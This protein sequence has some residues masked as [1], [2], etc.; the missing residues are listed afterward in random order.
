MQQVVSRAEWAAVAATALLLIL[1]FPNFEFYPLAWIALVPLIVVIARRPSPLRAFMYGWTAGTLFFYCS[2]YWL[3]YSMIHYGGLPTV[4]AYLLLVPAAL[5][6]GIFPGLFALLL[7]LAVQRWG[8]M[9]LVLAP[10][11]W[12]ALEWTRL[13]VTGQL[14]N[15]IGYSQAYEPLLI[16]AAT[17]GGVYAVSFLIL[18][19]NSAV[20]LL[21]L[22]RTKW[23]ILAAALMVLFVWFAIPLSAYVQAGSRYYS[24]D[25][26]SVAVV[27]LQPNVPMKLV[28]T[29]EEMKEL[30][31][32]HF[33]MSTTAL[34]SLSRDRGPIVVIWPE[35][36]MNFTYARD[37]AFQ[38][39]LTKFTKENRT[40]LIFNS[41]EPAPPDG[42]YNSALLINEWGGLIS[43]YDKIRLMPFGEYV[44]LPRWL[45]GASLITGL[46]GE[47]TPGTNYRLMPLGEHKAG[48]FI[49]IES[50]Y[51]WIARRM[52]SEGADFLINISNDG[53]L[54]PTAVMRQHLANAV[55]RAVENR[56][57][58]MRATN[59]GLSAYI[60]DH[61]KI[62]GQ[63]RAFQ[64]D[65]RVWT[66]SRA[67][68]VTDTI[69]TKHGDFFVH[70]CAVI[71]LAVLIA[72]LFKPAA[73]VM[74]SRS[75]GY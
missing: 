38:E 48:V 74:R 21:V 68:G 40:S 23:T 64:A 24:S 50:A 66:F 26:S 37:T 56:R 29:P 19:I 34:K 10:V 33:T 54:G 28:K 3:T 39:L 35:S 58:V 73:L 14:W 44:P 1:S 15:A 45:P 65:V 13:S 72:L 12:T 57:P 7:A 16:Q 2:C 51:P 20:A 59:S 63:T 53:Y 42:F 25:E 75:I 41:L 22:K 27:A 4:V 61:G 67:G 11:F 8:Y 6:V 36:P 32:R 69:Y 55:F 47:F 49:C 43:Q 46:V 30:L 17:W 70:L 52:T 31:D 60:N 71:T 5:V 9:A 62:S 18:T